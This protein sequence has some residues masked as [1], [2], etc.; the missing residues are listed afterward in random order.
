MGGDGVGSIV[1]GSLRGSCCG[2]VP[3]R[4]LASPL[5]AAATKS[6]QGLQVRKTGHAS[7][8]RMRSRVRLSAS[9]SPEA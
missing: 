5:F 3:C 8:L 4:A 9:G 2:A 1:R 7:T 6:E